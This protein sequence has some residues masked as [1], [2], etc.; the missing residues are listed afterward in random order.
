MRQKLVLAL[1][2]GICISMTACGNENTGETGQK[3][4]TSNTERPSQMVE[5]N[6]TE[7]LSEDQT[8]GLSENQTEGLSEDQI[9]DF[10][11]F[12]QDMSNYGFIRSEY[13][14]CEYVDL[15]EVF[16]SGAG[17]GEEMTEDDIA[18]FLKETGQEEMYTDCVKL[19]KENI[20]T[21]LLKKLGITLDEIKTEFNWVYLSEYDAYYQQAGDTNY[22]KYR[23][24]GGTKTGN[25]Y[26]LEFEPEDELGGY[27]KNCQTILM[28]TD[29]DY[30]FV[31]NDI[32]DAQE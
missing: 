21:F 28:E 12:I 17:I 3:T 23:C 20:D 6:Q 30:Q 19:S 4:Q 29:G 15:G 27:Y 22:V 2:L 5:E 25:Q 1:V 26:T 9:D 32:L 31:S 24:V 13:E 10:T 7:S 11:E 18:A 14:S 8:E 16:Y